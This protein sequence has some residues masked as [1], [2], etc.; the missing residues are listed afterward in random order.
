MGGGSGLRVVCVD[1]LEVLV[2]SGL[3]CCR[4]GSEGV[5]SGEV[6]LSVAQTQPCL[7]ARGWWN[8]RCN[9]IYDARL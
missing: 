2:V 6:S 1:F 7:L 3:W 4:E 8:A 9:H 5:L